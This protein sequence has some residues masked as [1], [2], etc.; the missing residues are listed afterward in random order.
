[1]EKYQ[2]Y[3][4]N[5]LS[6]GYIE[7]YCT[8][9]SDKKELKRAIRRGLEEHVEDLLGENIQLNHMITKLSCALNQIN[10]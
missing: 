3:I 7:N 10:K 1:M 9:D 4:E 8:K 2:N 6:K 5:S